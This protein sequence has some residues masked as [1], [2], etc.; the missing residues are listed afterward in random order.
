MQKNLPRNNHPHFTQFTYNAAKLIID[1]KLRIPV[2]ITREIKRAGN[3]LYKIEQGLI[4]VEADRF[5][6]KSLTTCYVLLS[7]K[8]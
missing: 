7:F 8:N 2:E 1:E 3:Q 4:R 6:R 5:G